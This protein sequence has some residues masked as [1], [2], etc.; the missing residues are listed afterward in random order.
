MLLVLIKKTLEGFVDLVAKEHAIQV[1]EF[2]WALGKI[3]VTGLDV[4]IKTFLSEPLAI[5]YF[6]LVVI[7]MSVVMTRNNILMFH[8]HCDGDRAEPWSHVWEGGDV[9][10][11]LLSKYLEELNESQSPKIPMFSK[12]NQIPFQ[13][14]IGMLQN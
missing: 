5:I 9:N 4:F 2:F 6:A 11:G 14:N 10:Q 12:E 13:F 8:A 7:S 3:N 1:M